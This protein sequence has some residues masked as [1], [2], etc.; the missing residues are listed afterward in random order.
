[1]SQLCFHLSSLLQ[2][3]VDQPSIN[4]LVSRLESLI[5]SGSFEEACKCLSAGLKRWLSGYPDPFVLCGNY[6]PFRNLES[7]RYSRNLDQSRIQ[8][9]D[10]P[11]IPVLLEKYRDPSPRGDYLLSGMMKLHTAIP[12]KVPSQSVLAKVKTSISK[13]G[14]DLNP[15]LIPLFRG[16][17]ERLANGLKARKRK[18]QTLAEIPA[19]LNKNSYSLVRK[20][21]V[22]RKDQDVYNLYAFLSQ[23][24]INDLIMAYP[25]EFA[26]CLITGERAVIEWDLIKIKSLRRNT[27]EPLGSIGIIPERGG[28]YRVV[29]VPCAPLLSLNKPV[30]DVLGRIAKGL[31]SSGVDSHD[32]AVQKISKLLGRKDLTFHCYDWK[33]FTDRFPRNLQRELLLALEAKGLIKP[34]DIAV[35]DCI[36]EALFDFRKEPVRYAVG[37]PQGTYA[38]FPEASVSHSLLLHTLWECVEGKAISPFTTKCPFIVIGDDVVIWHDKLADLYK[39]IMLELGVE[40]N[41]NKSIISKN[42]AEM[43]SKLITSDKA[44]LQK[45][46]E[47]IKGKASFIEAYR[48]YNGHIEV[49]APNAVLLFLPYPFGVLDREVPETLKVISEMAKYRRDLQH[50]TMNARDYQI[51]SGRNCYSDLY[52]QVSE[53]I[54]SDDW[55]STALIQSFKLDLD[56]IFKQMK[57]AESLSDIREILADSHP[58][59]ESIKN[60]WRI[61]EK[62]LPPLEYGP[63]VQPRSKRGSHTRDKDSE[64]VMDFLKPSV[65]NQLSQEIKEAQHGKGPKEVYTPVL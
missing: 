62:K 37:T 36:C 32:K 40:I 12:P 60:L 42:I 44:Y 6:F 23:P 53:V 18:Y 20:Q 59:F 22:P 10:I 41:V 33:D 8:V 31:P 38:S 26:D 55:R 13:E 45:K 54:P 52:K 15:T 28:K 63:S 9:P 5:P 43:C 24:K 39:Q 16:V 14:P 34:F 29:A 46:L 27:E 35:Q 48:Y 58:L 50:G 65:M 51:I 30:A 64:L 4:A 21:S 47:P 61:E 49:T 25:Q 2:D 7:A 3:E 1:M 11:V 19:A 17:C 56:D 57:S